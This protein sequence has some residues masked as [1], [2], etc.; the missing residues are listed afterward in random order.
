MLFPT[1]LIDET[2]I[3]INAIIDNKHYTKASL[4]RLI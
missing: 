4:T 3:E 2:Y 1:T